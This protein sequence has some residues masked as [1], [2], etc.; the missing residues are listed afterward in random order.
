MERYPSNDQF[1]D[2]D[3]LDAL[4]HPSQTFDHPSEVISSLCMFL[5]ISIKRRQP[6]QGIISSSTSASLGS[7]AGSPGFAPDEP[8]RFR[9]RRSAD[10]WTWGKNCSGTSPRV[11]VS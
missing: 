10:E 9:V 5:P 7:L 4:L 11:A 2:A 6:S 3:D 8:S 1:D